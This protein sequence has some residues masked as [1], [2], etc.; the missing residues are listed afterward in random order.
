MFHLTREA[1]TH[2]NK[3]LQIIEAKREATSC[4]ISE[5]PAFA[6][7][8]REVHII[9]QDLP[10][11]TLLPF[12]LTNSSTWTMGYCSVAKKKEDIVSS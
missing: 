7:M 2:T 9:G 3:P 5:T 10:I 4:H 6:Q 1:D 12:M 11:G 8:L